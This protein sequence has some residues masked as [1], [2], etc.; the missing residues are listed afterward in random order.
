[1]RVQNGS[2]CS[3]ELG[4]SDAVSVLLDLFGILVVDVHQVIV[5]AVVGLKEFVELCMNS[6]R[7][8]V[9]GPLKYQL[10]KRFGF[11]GVRS[12][13]WRS[14]LVRRYK[15]FGIILLQLVRH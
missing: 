12:K 14:A 6:L 5:G 2:R 11:S 9:F 15:G 13:I 4:A 3:T 8:P 1:M 7:V 10:V